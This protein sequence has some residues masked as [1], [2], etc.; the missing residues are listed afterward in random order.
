VPKEIRDL[1]GNTRPA[2]GST[3]IAVG[4][5]PVLIVGQ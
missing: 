1:A 5:E 2:T 4:P 3:R